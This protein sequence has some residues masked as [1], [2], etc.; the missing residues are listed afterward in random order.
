MLEQLYSQLPELHFDGIMGIST[1]ALTASYLGRARSS[2]AW[3]TRQDTLDSLQVVKSIYS[4]LRDRFDIFGHHS[5]KPFSKAWFARKLLPVGDFERSAVA[6]FLDGKLGVFNEEPLRQKLATFLVQDSQKHSVPC[7]WSQR[8]SVGVVCLTENSF[9]YVDRSLADLTPPQAIP[10]ILAST[11]IPGF[12]E[13]IKI[14]SP[15]DGKD[16]LWFD[17]GVR[18][19]YP[20]G[21]G[22]ELLKT[23]ANA[24]VEP[25]SAV[26]LTKLAPPCRNPLCPWHGTDKENVADAP[27]LELFLFNSDPIFAPDGTLVDPGQGEPLKQ[28]LDVAMR[29]IDIL[30][31][32]M[33]LGDLKDMYLRN[34][35]ARVGRKY[36]D[37]DRYVRV[38][39]L[40]PQRRI[41]KDSKEFSPA[42]IQGAMVEGTESA[43]RFLQQPCARLLDLLGSN[44]SGPK[45]PAFDVRAKVREI[46][47]LKPLT[48]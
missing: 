44:L 24:A 37:T 16:E 4:G 35:L 47:G 29:A 6:S 39:S 26:D 15:M 48:V 22:L 9:Q 3:P 41:P 14:P 10:W 30:Y 18:N 1:G 45:K 12:L 34:K 7:Y 5:T 27:V 21:R 2:D 13:P 23:L 46:P 8:V 25:A 36:K 42:E 11:S 32:E 20:Y 43:R 40:D 33:I 28:W 31:H 38:Y 17:G 19:R